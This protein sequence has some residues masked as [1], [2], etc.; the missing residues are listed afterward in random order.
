MNT[1]DFLFEQVQSKDKV[2]LI[3]PKGSY[4]YHD[5]MS[6]V[7]SYEK[8]FQSHG[9]GVGNKIGIFASNSLFWIAS[10]FACLK[11]GATAVPIATAISPEQ[12]F[13]NLSWINL[14][15]LCVEERLYRRFSA[16]IPNVNRFTEDTKFVEAADLVAKPQNVEEGA[17][18]AA[19][20]FTSGT[21]STPRLVRITHQNL[22][23]NT[24]S[25]IKSLNLDPSQRMMSVLPFYY[26]F[27]TS[28]LH[29]H[30]RVGGSLVLSE[31]M[32][33]P[34]I[35]LDLMEETGCTGLAGV[36]SNYQALL[37][38]TSFPQRELKD[39]KKIQQAG[40]KLP[41][42]LI[43]ELINCRPNSEIFIMYGQTEA[44]ARLSCLPPHLLKEKMGSIGKGLPGVQLKVVN[45]QGLEI[46][47][48]EVGEIVAHGENISPGYLNEPEAT[49]EKFKDGSLYTG[50]LATVDKDGYIYIVDRK[51]DFI[52]SYGNRVSSQDIESCILEL[53][54]I[55]AAAAIGV[56]DLIKGEAIYAFIMV[57]PG[58]TLTPKAVIAHVA[59]HLPNFM[60]P[61]EVKVIDNL[62]LNA[63]GKVI[64]TELRNLVG[65]QNES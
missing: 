29:T 18:D 25:I 27:G 4:T 2:A 48:D 57:K 19:L 52:K 26:C 43:N 49:R 58:T 10:Y 1:T 40:G 59:K 65:H 3:T 12:L 21:T 7:S 50:D 38:K 47:P 16:S 62:P 35:V 42:I 34:E 5:L 53:S 13:A 46:K 41:A 22:Q 17:G 44:T 36:P 51:S 60:V 31:G 9:L 15:L 39:L 28:L 63:N 33:F 8:Q 30:I 55:V 11:I 32:I 54:D 64:K 56:P 24:S 45:E 61:T 23:A 6:T 20:M 14:S 37:R